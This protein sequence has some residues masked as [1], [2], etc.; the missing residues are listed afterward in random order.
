MADSARSVAM[1][2]EDEAHDAIAREILSTVQQQDAGAFVFPWHAVT[3]G[4]PSNAFSGRKFKGGNVLVLWSAARR[5]GFRSHQWASPHAWTTRHGRIRPD[6]RGAEIL[7][8]VYDGEAKR[9]TKTTP[10]IRSKVGPLGADPA[11]GE[12]GRPVVGYRRE[13]WFNAEEVDGVTVVPPTLPSPSEAAAA[14]V[15]A[16]RRWSMLAGPAFET[17]GLRAHWRAEVDRVVV[18]DERSFPDQ[19]E[20]GLSGKE[21]YAGVLAH[22]CVHATGS[23]NRLARWTIEKYHTN[24]AARAR[25]ELVAEIGAAF[26]AGHFGLPTALRRDHGIYVRGWLEKLREKS[27]RPAFLSAVREAERASEFIL[28]RVRPPHPAP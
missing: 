4:L 28:E 9:W 1:L 7:I 18:P 20:S 10:G 25:E 5:H 3:G 15:R 8:P 17:G 2:A 27:Q 21:L 16:L 11:G 6:A 14:C 13:T 12:Y 26:L 22:E 24:K 19:P 23:R